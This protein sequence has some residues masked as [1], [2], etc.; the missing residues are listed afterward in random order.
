[1]G[2]R[3]FGCAL[4]ALLALVGSA[5]FAHGSVAFSLDDAYIHL[6]YAK[7]LWL[8]DGLS[9]NP[10]D[11]ELGASS[12]LWALLLAPLSSLPNVLRAVQIFTALLH[13]AGAY[14][15]GL[16]A[17]AFSP[18]PVAS[19]AAVL[20][21][22]HPLLLQASVSGMEVSCATFLLVSLTLAAVRDRYA[23]AAGLAFCA[24]F[25]RPEALC[26]ALV[27]AA[28][29]ATVQRRRQPLLIALAALAAMALW[30]GYCA[31][32]SG[33]ALPNTFYAKAGFQPLAGLAFLARRVFGEEPWLLGLGGAWLIASRVR[34]R[35]PDKF[36]LCLLAWLLSLLAI[37]FG[38]A[39]SPDLLFT[40]QRYFACFAFLPCA[41][42]CGAIAQARTRWLVLPVVLASLALLPRSLERTR[43][44]EHNTRVLH[45]DVAAF[46]HA[47]LPREMTI[48]VEGAGALRYFTARE[49]RVIDVLGLN[50]RSV[51]HAGSSD[52]RLC[53]IASRLPSYLFLPD[54]L[55]GPLSAMFEGTIV[56]QF[57]EERFSHVLEPYPWT[58]HVV[59]VS[60]LRE[61]MFSRCRFELTAAN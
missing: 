2:M 56:R 41:L 7:S 33:Y 19:S 9:Y 15:T 42:A 10:G 4:G 50:D 27:L 1:M 23:V 60:G 12:P 17:S 40:Q 57:R 35:A 22:L 32:I 14:A 21:A 36:E 5:W 38:R 28:G 34:W 47:Q 51:M 25:A 16:L 54:A 8:G 58:V 59:E 29:L 46:V 37:A 49:L 53:A 52:A 3:H 18:R 45:V 48:A 6:A 20:F 26:F 13:A 30:S 24:V 43:A 39:L 44:Q 61:P 55:L 31:A 11:W